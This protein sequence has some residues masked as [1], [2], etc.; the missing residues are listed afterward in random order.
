MIS[1]KQINLLGGLPQL[2][3]QLDRKKP[4]A[5]TVLTD[6]KFTED[7]DHIA[8]ASDPYKSYGKK[9]LRQPKSQD[10]Q[11]KNR[12]ALQSQLKQ[13]QLV[14]LSTKDYRTTVRGTDHNAFAGL[15]TPSGNTSLIIAPILNTTGTATATEPSINFNASEVGAN[16]G[17][18]M[19][20]INVDIKREA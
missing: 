4:A 14:K 9:R 20:Q 10:M 6:K 17:T 5:K 3:N 12:V 15:S 2:I 1:G 18:G 7:N 16:K 8:I 11:R 19:D 13:K